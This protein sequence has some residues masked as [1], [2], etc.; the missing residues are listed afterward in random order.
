LKKIKIM[1]VDD[2]LVIRE[3]L[4]Q[5]LGIE[6]NIDVVAEVE[7]GFECLSL[8]GVYQPDIILMDIR[9][10]GISGIETTRRICERYPHIKVIMLTIYE[11]EHYITEAIQ[12]GARGYVLKNV[13]R[14]ELIKIIYSVIQDQAYLD[15]SVTARV[16]NYVRKDNKNKQDDID[17]QVSLLTVRELEVLRGLVKGYSDRIIAKSL[18]ISEHTVRSHVKSIYRKLMVSSRSQAVSKAL[19]CEIIIGDYVSNLNESAVVKDITYN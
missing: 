15:P 18:G 11:D 10:P 14:E 12:A 16:F 5:L 4:K 17:S 13:K 19:Q 3:G 1:I 6:D 7:S 8:V 2:H 9:L